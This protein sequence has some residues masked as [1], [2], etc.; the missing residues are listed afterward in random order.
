M[1]TSVDE[2]AAMADVGKWKAETYGAQLL[3]VLHHR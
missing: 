2:L 1:P 3:A